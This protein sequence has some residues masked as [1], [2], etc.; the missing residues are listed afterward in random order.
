LPGVPQW[1][2][3]GT[4]ERVV[5]GCL[6]RTRLC[7]PQRLPPPP[8]VIRGKAVLC[9]QEGTP[10]TLFGRFVALDRRLRR[11]RRRGK[12]AAAVVPEAAAEVS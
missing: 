11:T 6:A 8:L 10:V 4:G 2:W 3:S 7:W 12:S 5:A 1:V 9:D